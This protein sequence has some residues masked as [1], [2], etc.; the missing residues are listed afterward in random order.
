MAPARGTDQ[1]G[2]G[3]HRS[4]LTMR[5]AWS[6]T[7]ERSAVTPRVVVKE[8][9]P[10]RLG[11]TSTSSTTRRPSSSRSPSCRLSF[12]VLCGEEK[13]AFPYSVPAAAPALL[14]TEPAPRPRSEGCP[15]ARR[16][17]NC[18]STVRLR[19]Y[20]VL[21]R[22]VDPDQLQHARHRADGPVRARDGYGVKPHGRDRRGRL[23]ARDPGRR[24]LQ[25]PSPAVLRDEGD[26]GRQEGDLRRVH[27]VHGG[28]RRRGH[29]SEAYQRSPH[30]RQVPQKRHFNARLGICRRQ[31][32]QGRV[33]RMRG[34][35]VPIR[36]SSHILRRARTAR[37]ITGPWVLAL[38]RD[39]ALE[40]LGCRH[41]DG[42]HLPL[43]SGQAIERDYRRASPR[44]QLVRKSLRA[45]TRQPS[46][47]SS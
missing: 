24:L 14:R 27:Q 3:H 7:N 22:S 21:I 36:R 28:E 16:P 37:S 5:E 20:Y 30:A 29:G 10:D 35:T 1:G 26:E 33:C 34:P 44:Q 15:R 43:L 45:I 4:L 38:R 6:Q 41:N 40:H 39:S 18:G 25:L 12:A 46:T 47:F 17:R 9:P 23:A 31:A 13:Q 42:A 19:G 2:G 32:G 8:D 11:G